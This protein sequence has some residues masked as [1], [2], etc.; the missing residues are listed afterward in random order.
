[1]SEELNRERRELVDL[2]RFGL[3]QTVSG[4]PFPPSQRGAPLV[5]DT[6]AGADPAAAVA[7]VLA[8]AE[9][10]LALVVAMPGERAR[11]VR[12][13]LDVLGRGEVP[14]VTGGIT[15][16]GSDVAGLVPEGVEEPGADLPAAVAAACAGEGPVRWVVLGPATNLARALTELPDLRARVV[17]T[18]SG[19]AHDINP[20]ADPEA[21]ADVLATAELPKLVLAAAA[22]GTPT[23]GE[24]I[25]PGWA[26]VLAPNPER[27]SSAQGPALA[28]AAALQLP[29]VDLLRD[30][31][32][33]VDGRLARDPAGHL[34]RT[35]ED[36][37]LPAFRRWL[38]TGLRHPAEGTR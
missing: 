16:A 25:D 19:G 11:F 15:A 23:T 17:A 10:A 28:M 36:V 32:S 24:L 31:V 13:L 8:A 2:A 30:R 5:V 3:P 34:V 33:L 4:T 21:F 20:L 37:D 22:A 38:T 12:H 27:L 7:L 18:L 9:P 35:C 6:D 14:V 26:R 1:M 29:F